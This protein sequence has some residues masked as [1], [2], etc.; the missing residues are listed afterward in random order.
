[1]PSMKSERRI[2]FQAQISYFS[3]RL[4]PQLQVNSA[5]ERTRSVSASLRYKSTRK[6]C[7]RKLP[8]SL[9]HTHYNNVGVT[10]PLQ[11]RRKKKKFLNFFKE[12]Q[13]H[14]TD[15]RFF[16]FALCAQPSKDIKK[17]PHSYE[18]GFSLA[19]PFKID[20]QSKFFRNRSVV[21]SHRIDLSLGDDGKSVFPAICRGVLSCLQTNLCKSKRRIRSM[22]NR[23]CYKNFRFSF[24]H[25]EIKKVIAR[26]HF[27]SAICVRNI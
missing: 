9:L 13:N 11:N 2:A 15:G 10:N 16:C 23:I 26:L 22:I 8:Q 17:N 20:P 24:F 19:H 3:E 25:A 14:P 27:F 5:G 6:D 21:F 1:M 18:C 4:A 12:N 7:N